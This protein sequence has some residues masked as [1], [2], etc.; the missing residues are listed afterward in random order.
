[1]IDFL[2][3][4][5]SYVAKGGPEALAVLGW[6]LYLLE[7]FII[8]RSREERYREDLRGLRNDYETLS[9]N[10]IKTIQDFTV[11]LEVLRDRGTR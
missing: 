9:G 11:I 6:G 3:E 10:A 4:M 7:R 1:M 5:M 2:L 8:G